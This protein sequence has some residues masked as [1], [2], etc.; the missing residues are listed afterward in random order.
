MTTTRYR[1]TSAY[2]NIRTAGSMHPGAHGGWMQFGYYRGAVLDGANIH[3]AD[4]Q[5]L[6][7][8]GA[9]EEVRNAA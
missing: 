2:V 7:R 3:P 1:V 6:L 4:V 9:I 8:K 5:R